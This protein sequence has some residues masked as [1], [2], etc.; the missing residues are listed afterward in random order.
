[1]K[2]YNLTN[3][4]DSNNEKSNKYRIFI[5]IILA[6]SIF[7]GIKMKLCISEINQ[8]EEY[9]DKHNIKENKIIE[10]SSNTTILKQVKDIYSIIGSNNIDEYIC[11][12]NNI[13]VKGK[14]I[15]IDILDSIKRMDNITN[16]SIENIKRENE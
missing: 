11:I 3:F 10:N 5:I 14:C 12:N 7:I 1:M 4:I 13:E 8:I 2:N 15:N 16:Y 6:V 9:I